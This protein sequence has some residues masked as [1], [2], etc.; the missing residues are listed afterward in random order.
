M[1]IYTFPAHFDVQNHHRA[2]TLTHTQRESKYYLQL[3]YESGGTGALKNDYTA[4]SNMLNDSLWS[5]YTPKNS[6]GRKL[7]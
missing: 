5:L 1:E 2:H 3:H 4:S 6:Q 7:S